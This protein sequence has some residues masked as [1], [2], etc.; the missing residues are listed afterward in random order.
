MSFQVQ[1]GGRLAVVTGSW[2][3]SSLPGGCQVEV[4][5]T[6]RAN[7]VV[8]TAT[9]RV[10]REHVREDEYCDP[11]VTWSTGTS[12]VLLDEPLSTRTVVTSG[13]LLRAGEEV[14][15][16]GPARVPRR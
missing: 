6:E 10:T 11:P 2:R 4:T 3:N 7:R 12:Y 9:T 13:P 14:D 15:P 1:Q 5:A 16:A 8:L